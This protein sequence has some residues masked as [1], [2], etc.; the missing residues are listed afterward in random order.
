MLHDPCNM[1]MRAV[2]KRVDVNL[3]R[4]R[5]VTVE[6]H[7]TVARDHHGF[8][9]IALK[10]GL[11]A[12]NFHGAA[13]QDVRGANDQR[14]P[15]VGRHLQGFSVRM[16]DAILG[17]FELE[18]IYQILEPLA[19]LGQVDCIG[20]GAQDRDAGVFERVGKL[21]RGLPT[22]LHNHA[23]QRA[24]LLLNS[25]DFHHMLIGQRLKIQSV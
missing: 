21:E 22:E 3:N 9:N 20:C 17:L 7:R 5:E 25:Q 12:D 11:V 6:Q 4:T 8:G 23:M 13:A 18:G 10:V 1:H 24:V 2:A 15:N 16:G 19:V 14:E